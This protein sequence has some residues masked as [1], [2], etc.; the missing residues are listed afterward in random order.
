MEPFEVRRTRRAGSPRPAVEGLEV[1]QLLSYS[2]LG[3]SLPDLT[4]TGVAAPVAAYSHTLTVSVDVRNLGASSTV[5]PLA[6]QPGAVSSADAPPSEVTVFLSRSPRAG[7]APLVPIGTVEVPAVAQNSLVTVTKTLQ[8]PPRFRSLPPNGG[9]VYAYFRIDQAQSIREHDKRNNFSRTG[10]PIQVAVGLPDL[11]GVALDVP[12]V[13]QPGDVIAPT[14]RVA[15]FGTTNT[16]LQSSFEVDLV[17]STDQNF[18]PGDSV[19]QRFVVSSLPP[20]AEVPMRNAVLGDVS[21]NVPINEIT[22]HNP[23]PVQ[24]PTQP[25]QYYIGVV[26]DP[27]NVIREINEVGRGPNPRL[28]PIHPVGPPSHTLP[29]AGILSDPAPLGNVFPIPAFGPIQTPGVTTTLE[30]ITATTTG[31]GYTTNG[32]ASVSQAAM[33]SQAV[34]DATPLRRRHPAQRSALRALLRR[35]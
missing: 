15:N 18:G 9:T 20:L 30:D 24:L 26:V 29:P 28:E 5:E 16:D 2:P 14:I 27:Q 12:P 13:M 23:V 11:Y 3:F 32:N 34:A 22:L 25:G 7:R 19:L 31:S 1:R 8:M 35:S 17:A 21:I 4:V 10:V 33:L 6:L